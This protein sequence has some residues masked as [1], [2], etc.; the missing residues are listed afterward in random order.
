MV[1][2]INDKGPSNKSA[3]TKAILGCYLAGVFGNI[4]AKYNENMNKDQELLPENKD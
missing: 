4:T 1:G 2:N 3:I